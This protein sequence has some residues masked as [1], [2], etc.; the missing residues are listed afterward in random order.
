MIL[1]QNR[2]IDQWNH[3]EDIHIEPHTKGCLTF[4][5]ED[6]IHTGN[7]TDSS[8][9][10]TGQAKGCMEKNANRSIIIILYKINSNGSKTST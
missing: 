10:C 3:I 1:A 9:N 4:D 6:G 5:K 2:H 7:N 8:I